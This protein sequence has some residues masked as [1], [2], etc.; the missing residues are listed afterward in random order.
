[1][2][3][4]CITHHYF[5]QKFGVD[6]PIIN[7]DQMPLHRNECSKQATLAFK[8]LETF[9]KENAYLSTES[10][11]VFTQVSTDENIK[12]LPEFA[13]TGTGKRPPRM[14]AHD[15]IHHQWALKGLHRLEQM[16]IT[17]QHLQ[18]HRVCNLCY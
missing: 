11:A 16:L 6:P 7:G 18:S 1:M 10:V 4:V 3:N 12:L 2:K 14:D 9:V 8:N 17:I 5:L 15:G 13:F